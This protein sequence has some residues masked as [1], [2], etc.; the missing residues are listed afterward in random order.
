MLENLP[1]KSNEE[2]EMSSS[3]P[4]YLPIYKKGLLSHE[5]YE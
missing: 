3:E 5:V 2:E 4:D 1:I